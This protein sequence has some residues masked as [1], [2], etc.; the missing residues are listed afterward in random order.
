MSTTLMKLNASWERV[1]S[2]FGITLTLTATN[3]FVAIVVA[4]AGTILGNSLLFTGARI[5]V[6]TGLGVMTWGR[7]TTERPW[8]FLGGAWTLAQVILMAFVMNGEPT[9]AVAASALISL[10]AAVFVGI[11]LWALPRRPQPRA[12]RKL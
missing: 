2:G 7:L 6:L 5:A 3:M 8:S 1:M 11:V 12:V 4:L 10:I 9:L